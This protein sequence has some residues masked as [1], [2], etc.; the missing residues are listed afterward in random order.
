M[1]NTF[2][3]NFI[4]HPKVTITAISFQLCQVCILEVVFTFSNVE[5]AK[6]GTLINVCHHF[7]SD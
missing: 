6:V 3:L 1:E 2:E 4:T 5:A 7:C